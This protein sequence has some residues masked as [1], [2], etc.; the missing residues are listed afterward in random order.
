MPRFLADENFNG[1]ILRGIRLRQPNIDLLRVQDVEIAGAEDD[2][3]LE[4]AARADRIILTHD[5]STMPRFA[6]ERVLAHR[7]MPGVV[8]VNDRM[9]V[10]QAIEELLLVAQCSFEREWEDRVLFL[11][12]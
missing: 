6:D 11:P 10:R 1:D 5:R 12:L 4:W 9:A 7:R 8:V 2:S 3:V